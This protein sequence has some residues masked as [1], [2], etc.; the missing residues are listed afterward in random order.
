MRI[1]TLASL[2]AIGTA[3]ALTTPTP[4]LAAE[5]PRHCVVDLSQGPAAQPVCV[6]SFT[7]AIARATGGRVIDAPADPAKALKDRKLADRIYNSPGGAPPLAKAD[8]PRPAAMAAADSGGVIVATFFEHWNYQGSSLTF[9]APAKC[10]DDGGWDW[11]YSTLKYN[12]AV[13]SFFTAGNC[14]VELF[15][16]TYFKGAHAYY[17]NAVPRLTVMNDAASSIR[18]H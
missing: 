18:L 11:G 10:K 14:H 5:A 3:V 16:D 6:T 15:E 7:A 8:G 13:S 17:E 1:R 2:A 9:T 4:T 12:D